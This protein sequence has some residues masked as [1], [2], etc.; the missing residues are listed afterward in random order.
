MDRPINPITPETTYKCYLTNYVDGVHGK[1]V[2]YRLNI[3]NVKEE[4][5]KSFEGVL[6]Q[7]KPEGKWTIW[8]KNGQ[9]DAPLFYLCPINSLK[10]N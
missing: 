2:L 9:P 5:F 7:G 10:P 1:L 6:D 4:N 3:E 8:Y